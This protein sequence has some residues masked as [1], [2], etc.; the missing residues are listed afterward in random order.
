M[1]PDGAQAALAAAFARMRGRGYADR[2]RGRAVHLVAM[3]C[4]REA[5]NLLEVRAEPVE[6]S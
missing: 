5:R 1:L 2:Y 6:N 4:G 3:A